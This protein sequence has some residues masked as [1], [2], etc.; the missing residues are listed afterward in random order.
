MLWPYKMMQNGQEILKNKL[1]T[2]LTIIKAWFI[3]H[4]SSKRLFI[5]KITHY[6][7]P[8]NLITADV[9][10]ELGNTTLGGK[11]T[12]TNEL[13]HHKPEKIKNFNFPSSWD[14]T[15]GLNREVAGERLQTEPFLYECAQIYVNWA[16]QASNQ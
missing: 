1:S 8:E 3:F 10:W 13:L 9:R 11:R 7:I 2:R 14:I 4:S 12:G 6:I 5:Q 16:L 15:I